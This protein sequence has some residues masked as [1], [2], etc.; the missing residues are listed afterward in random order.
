MTRNV[1]IN[2]SGMNWPLLSLAAGSFATGTEAYVYVSQLEQLA[3]DLQTSLAATGALAATFAITYAVFAPVIAAKTTKVDRRTL[4]VAGLAAIGLLNLFAAT[5]DS[6]ATLLL[7]R[8]ACGLAAA[9]AG[10]ASSAAAA[11]L[12]PPERRGRAMATVLAGLTLAFVLGIPMGSVVGAWGG[13]RATFAFAGA[14]ALVTAIIVRMVL[15]PIASMRANSLTQL[16][17]AFRPEIARTLLMTAIGFAA[18]F[19]V[20]A[21]I[22]PVAG[23]IAGIRGSAVGGLQALIGVGSIAGVVFGGRFADRA[24]AFQLIRLTFVASAGALSLYSLAPVMQISPQF[25]LYPLSLAMVAGAATLFMRTPL[26]Q[27]S[28]VRIHPSQAPVLL[29]LNGSMVFAGQGIGA[30]LGALTI[31]GLGVDAL[32]FV[33]ATVALLGAFV[34]IGVWPRRSIPSVDLAAE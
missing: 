12:V 27:A 1:D 26:I 24:D 22:G 3:R 17:I 19:C 32:G 13:W 30:A 34:T 15:P 11:A 20:V 5:V 29:A 10:P 25:A 21:Y 6:F 28:L 8:M 18:T 33:G 23:E 14:I 9:T 2:E 4:V 31:A 16:A 7:I